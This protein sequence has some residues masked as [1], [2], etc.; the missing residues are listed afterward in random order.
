MSYYNH[1]SYS[2]CKKKIHHSKEMQSV[3]IPYIW[4]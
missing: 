4:E 3:H 2:N 1:N